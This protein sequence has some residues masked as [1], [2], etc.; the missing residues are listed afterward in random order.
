[1][2]SKEQ[3]IDFIDEL[4][5]IETVIPMVE[6]YYY[7]NNE[8]FS[9][10]HSNKYPKLH[11]SYLDLIKNNKILIIQETLSNK[12]VDLCYLVNNIDVKEYQIDGKN[13]ISLNKHKCILDSNGYLLDLVT[14]K[15]IYFY[16]VT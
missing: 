5:D 3:I 14:K 2:L 8:L 7:S 13:I 12:D 9:I 11:K 1:M 15:N 16:I 10:K 4:V 6:K